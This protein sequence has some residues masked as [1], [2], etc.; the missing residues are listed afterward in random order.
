MADAPISASH[1]TRDDIAKMEFGL[2]D[3]IEEAETSA[4]EKQETLARRKSSVEFENLMLIRIARLGA[5]A[6]YLR[7]IDDFQRSKAADAPVQKQAD[8]KP[9]APVETLP[10]A[11]QGPDPLDDF[12]D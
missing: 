7:K 3:F 9:S 2:R 10:P 12:G 1:T 11:K 5:L 8:E 4:W 6:A